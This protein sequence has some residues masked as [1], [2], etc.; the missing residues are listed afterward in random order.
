[1]FLNSYPGFL[2]PSWP[3]SV[4]LNRRGESQLTTPVMW[5]AF[6]LLLFNICM[7]L[8]AQMIRSFGWGIINM[9][10]IPSYRSPPQTHWVML[11]ISYPIGAVGGWMRCSGLW[12][13]PSKTD[14]LWL[15][16]FLGNKVL[17][18][19]VLDEV[20]LPETGFARNLGVLSDLCFCLKSK[21]QL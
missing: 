4:T 13:I 8:L 1:M 5:G 15:F 16:S 17:L 7:K 9:Q 20:A 14:W 11:W 18:S 6:S 3:I 21:W 10:M 19:L 12:L 2:F